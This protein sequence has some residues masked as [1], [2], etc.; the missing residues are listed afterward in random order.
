MLEISLQ[1]QL[2]SFNLLENLLKVLEANTAN[3]KLHSN[4]EQEM[5]ALKLKPQWT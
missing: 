3:Q 5:W 1:P 2:D 4:N